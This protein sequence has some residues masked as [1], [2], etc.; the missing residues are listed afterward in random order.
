MAMAI[1]GF[2]PTDPRVQLEILREKFKNA[3]STIQRLEKV[4][5]QAHANLARKEAEA[6]HLRNERDGLKLK[7]ELAKRDLR[8]SEEKYTKRSNTSKSR[9]IIASILFF[10]SSASVGFGTSYLTSSSFHSVGLILMAFAIALYIMGTLVTT[11][12]T[13]E[14]GN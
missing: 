6:S 12:F 14:G 8:Y 13:F 9:A 1:N 4:L 2:D 7:W 11:V 5:E 3:E 10:F